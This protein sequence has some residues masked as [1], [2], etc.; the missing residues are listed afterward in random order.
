MCLA[1]RNEGVYQSINVKN[2][3]IVNGI[4]V[5]LQVLDLAR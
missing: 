1:N 3:I 4:D 2:K 5:V